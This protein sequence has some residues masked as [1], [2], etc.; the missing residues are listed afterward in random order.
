MGERPYPGALAQIEG[1]STLESGWNGHHAAAISPGTREAAVRLLDQIWHEFK[2]SV[3]EPSIVVPTSDGGVALE[4]IV[5]DGDAE[6]GVEIVCLPSRYEYSVRDRATG[7]LGEESESA[8]P[9]FLLLH[10]IKTRVA[11]H[12]VVSR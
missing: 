4:W 7:R 3:P 1:F 12:K 10:V 6:R 8:D 2:V 9:G 11:G 5:K